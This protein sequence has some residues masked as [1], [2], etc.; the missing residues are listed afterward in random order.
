MFIAHTKDT[1]SEV[2]LDALKIRQQVFVQEQHVPETI[3]IDQNEAYTIHF[4]LYLESKQPAATLRLLPYNQEKIKIQR[5]AVL[6]NFRKKGLGRVIMEAA[7]TFAK[8]Q[9]YQSMILGA[10]LTALPFYESLGYHKDGEEFL[11]AGIRH[12]NMAKDLD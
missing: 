7:E 5:M 8:E 6:S 10:Q 3:E 1:M 4:V 12:V 2:Y 11:E 9:G